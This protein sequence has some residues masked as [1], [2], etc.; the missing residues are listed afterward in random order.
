MLKG[1][2]SFW[3]C[4]LDTKA[5]GHFV[6]GGF[7]ANQN[8]QNRKLYLK[9]F[10][11]EKCKNPLLFKRDNRLIDLFS[12]SN[13]IPLKTI[14]MKMSKCANKLKN[15]NSHTS[16]LW[17]ACSNSFTTIFIS[18][19]YCI[20]IS[21]VK[22]NGGWSNWMPYTKCSKSCG[23]GSQVSTRTC[24]NPAP[25]HGGMECSGLA[26]RTRECNTNPCP[27]MIFWYLRVHTRLV[28]KL[29]FWY[30]SDIK[31]ALMKYTSKFLS[32]KISK[33]LSWHIVV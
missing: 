17:N 21:Y 14:K 11:D 10:K 8:R 19:C 27:S 5:P 12:L 24:D 29:Q 9:L 30:E 15:P 13:R 22:V 7:K 6:K 28:V 31:A 32:R 23:S 18:L 3:G 2:H 33:V 16:S 20:N 26:E 1:L 4:K 25:A